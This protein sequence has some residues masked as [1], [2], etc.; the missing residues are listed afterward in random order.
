M[1]RS[2]L[3][4]SLLRPGRRGSSRR[5]RP[6]R[7]KRRGRSLAWSLLAL[8]LDRTARLLLEIIISPL[9]I[10]GEII[11]G[12]RS[13]RQGWI[14]YYMMFCLALLLTWLGAS[15]ALGRNERAG[16]AA[17]SRFSQ[18]K[19]EVDSC[20]YAAEI[21][22]YALKT[23]LDPSLV[24]A[25]I[26][27]ESAFNPNAISPKG[28]RGLMQIMPEVFKALNPESKCQADHEPPSCGE[29]CIFDPVT[30]IKT[31]VKLLRSLIEDFDGDVITA[32]A[33][34][35]AGG[36]AA[37][38]YQ[39]D[40]TPDG[41]PPYPETQQYARRIALLWPAFRSQG[42]HRAVFL[43]NLVVKVNSWAAWA[44]LAAWGLLFLWIVRRIRI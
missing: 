5:A 36:E 14:F 22:L 15:S 16:L 29:D 18:G 2:R 39:G 25:V 13:T 8:P 23:D 21:N 42:A 19:A 20:P 32:L 12:R 41:L 37:R 6:F 17:L 40:K 9:G 1:R 34:Y 28:A 24:A 10:C 30:N 31:G 26:A 33:A 3:L 38:K 11:R 35:N 4:A 7:I 44:N 43:T 27:Q